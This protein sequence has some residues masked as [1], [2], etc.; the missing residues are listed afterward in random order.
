MITQVK[1]IASRAGRR[2]FMVFM[3][4]EHFGDPKIP[5]AQIADRVSGWNTDYTVEVERVQLA[6]NGNYARLYVTTSDKNV[7]AVDI[8][9]GVDAEYKILT[10][11]RP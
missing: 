8:R 10:Q 9:R 4:G 5:A 3:Q 7:S 6:G 11:Q 1:L 2:K